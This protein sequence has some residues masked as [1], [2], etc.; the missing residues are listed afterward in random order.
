MIKGCSKKIYH[1]RNASSKYFEEVY[2][3]LK[4]GISVPCEGSSSSSLAEEA[5]RIIKEAGVLL[6]NAK[7]NRSSPT[8]RLSCFLVGVFTSSAI[9]GI[10][11]LL[12][13]I[14]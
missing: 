2:F 14:Q 1:V 5:E 3:V 6:N 8:S 4:D 11:T 13:T 10:I 9:L 7:P 12:L